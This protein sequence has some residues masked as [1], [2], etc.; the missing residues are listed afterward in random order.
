[1]EPILAGIDFGAKRSG[2]TAI[3]V[4]QTQ[5]VQIFQA[6]AKQDA[7]IWVREILLDLGVTAVA[8]D[9][10]LS[11][12]GALVG[13]NA[14]DN[15]H[16]RKADIESKAMSPMF[17]GG[18]TARAIELKSWADHNGMEMYETYPKKTA[19]HLNLDMN[20][21]KKDQQYL[22]TATKELFRAMNCSAVEVENWHQFDALLALHS[23][24]RI[25]IGKAKVLG[26]SREGL[27]YF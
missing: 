9:A 2:F 10:P 13:L 8:I 14:F 26:D 17:L 4:Q 21:Y 24:L 12:P 11:L 7:D 20:S 18:L 16:Y 6:K 23:M 3:A 5:L 15:F 27:M 22:A 25:H 19:L 1:M